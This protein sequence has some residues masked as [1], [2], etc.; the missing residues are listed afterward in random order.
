[1]ILPLLV[2]YENEKQIHGHSQFL[3]GF[4]LKYEPILDLSPH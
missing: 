2:K 1:M 4:S 3:T